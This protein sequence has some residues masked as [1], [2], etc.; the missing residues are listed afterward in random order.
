[1]HTSCHRCPGHAWIFFRSHFLFGSQDFLSQLAKCRNGLHRIHWIA[2]DVYS[3]LSYRGMPPDKEACGG[4]STRSRSR[5]REGGSTRPQTAG[6]VERRT[7]TGSKAVA[8]ANKAAE[9]AKSAE[10][11]ACDAASS[12][13]VAAIA[14]AFAA[15][16]AAAAANAVSSKDV[17][18]Q[19]RQWHRH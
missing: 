16:A 12:A 13:Q 9:L 3:R 4:S 2:T 19:R 5:S 7:R 1:M 6:I 15:A 14:A 10:K 18:R 11:K 8:A 17:R